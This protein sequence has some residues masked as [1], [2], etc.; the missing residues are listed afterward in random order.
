VDDLRLAVPLGGAGGGV[1]LDLRDDVL[2]CDLRLLGNQVLA[3]LLSDRRDARGDLAV[4][5]QRRG[6]PGRGLA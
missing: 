4:S 3:V 1:G 6:G 2:R 5:A